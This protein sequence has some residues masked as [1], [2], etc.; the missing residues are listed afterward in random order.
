MSTL[1][2]RLRR[3]ERKLEGERTIAP[4]LA[5]RVRHRVERAPIARCRRPLPAA[6]RSTRR[7]SARGRSAGRRPRAAPGGAATTTTSA[8][9]T[10][11]GRRLANR[12]RPPR[13]A[14]SACSGRTARRRI[15]P[16]RAADRAEQD[17]VGTA[18]G[19][20]VLGPDRDAVRV[21]RDAAGQDLDPVDRE[22]EPSPGRVDD[23]PRGV[24]DLG[25]DPVPRDRDDPVRRSKVTLR[26]RAGPRST[27]WRANATATPLISAPWSLFVATRYA[28]SDASMMLVD[29]PWPVTTSAPGPRPTSGGS[30]PAPGPA[31]PRPPTRP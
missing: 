3:V 26:L 15:R 2:R 27:R 31:R 13:S 25:P 22:A 21:D 17:R 14:K 28:S 8:G 12:P 20:D 18:T 29:N 23:P 24:D 19:L 6:R 1:V 10:V 30:G 7:R 4:D 11:T 9:W 16:L 5:S